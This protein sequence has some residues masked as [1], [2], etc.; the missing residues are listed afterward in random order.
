MPPSRNLAARAGAWSARHRKIAIFGWLAF[1]IVAFMAGN[2]AG[3]KNLEDSDTGNG[4][5]RVADEAIDG[6]GFRDRAGE[7]V[8]VQSRDGTL[9]ASAPAF[10]SAVRD[11]ERRLSAESAIERIE[12][13][14]AKDNEG[15]I[16]RDGR[17][18]IISFEIKGDP[19]EADKKI[20]PILAAV[21]AAQKAHPDLRVEQFGDASA[22]KA[23]SK[24]FEDDFKRA[25]F[26]SLPI[27]LL[28]LLIAFGALVA[29]G[30]PLLLA[31]TAVAATL[32]LLGPISQLFPVDESISSVIL[33]IGLAV[34]VDYS[35]FYLRRERE[36]RAAGRDE[37]AALAAA[38]AT[39]G[40]AVLISGLTVMVAMAGMYLAGNAVFTSFA[41]GTILVVGVAMLGSVTVLPA[42]MSKL[43]DRVNSGRV[44]FLAKR[45]ERSGG[46]SR[47]WGAILD[48]VLRRPWL[49]AIAS[50]T[51]LVV[52]A[53]PA[54]NLHTV[55]PGIQGLPR[56]LAVM[57]TYDRIQAAFP[58]GNVPAVA[59]VRA[60]DVTAPAVKQGIADLE[61]A[62]LASGQ[63]GEPI[64]V[65][66]N[67]AKDV[68]L[69]SIPLQGEGTDEK[70]DAALA[71]LRGK[72]IPATIDRVPGVGTDVTGFTAGSR[73]FT[74]QLKRSLPYVFAFVLT[75]AF[76]LLL[77]TFRSIVVPIKAIIL[78]LLSVGAAYGV[79]VWVFQYGNLEGLLDFESIG[80]ITSWLPLFLFVILFGLSMDYHV[81]ILSRIREAVD[82]GMATDQA[83]SYGIK[84]TAGVVT[85]AAA[86]MIGVFAIFATLSSLEF[87]QMGVGLAVA[88][89]IDATLV[90]AVL[91]PATMKLLG[92]SNWYLPRA[93]SWLPKVDHE[94]PAP[95]GA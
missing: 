70:S 93:L 20:D 31:L 45:R 27:T 9:R 18:A 66:V 73:D 60:D 13:P 75:L 40:R 52:I 24:S 30:I 74:D 51:V 72:L 81:L 32:G 48:R 86:V 76:L 54:L 6:A 44:P 33:L 15:Q 4:E 80:G 91:L 12:S 37:G 25:E 14:L 49:S 89:A 79:L 17:S 2:A 64:D 67:P 38:A 35:M 11:V 21:A 59:V 69:V 47:L 3:M 88:V 58:G 56:D 95:A 55:N 90:R 41:T 57:Q 71:T 39:S 83:V 92:E 26:L 53:L 82:G 5:S 61:K 65:E 8:L 22:D 16:S 78:N 68:A 84:A 43:G 50:A 34:G 85:S 94:A 77:V 46:E 19:D 1:V 63:M 10:T 36:E 28:I 62:A 87:K 23:L 42:L 29:A 7:Q